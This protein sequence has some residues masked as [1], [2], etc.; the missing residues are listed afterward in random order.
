MGDGLGGN[1]R[2]WDSVLKGIINR[3]SQYGILCT[4]MS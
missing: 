1:P 3:T 4:R 2:H